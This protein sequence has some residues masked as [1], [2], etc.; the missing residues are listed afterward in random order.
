M[1]NVEELPSEEEVQ[2]HNATHV[3][4]RSWCPHCVKG[5]LKASAHRGQDRSKN[6]VPTVSMGYFYVIKAEA[7]DERGPPTLA[8]VDDKTGMLTGAVLR[9]KGVEEWSIRVVKGFVEMLGYK[10][11]IMKSDNENAI[12]ALKTEVKTASQVEMITEQ[13]PAYDSRAAGQ[14]DNGVQRLQ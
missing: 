4:Y 13:S 9:Q 8:L 11:V 10:K 7:E 14:A 6:K 1:A 2:M 5:Q 12:M 3:P